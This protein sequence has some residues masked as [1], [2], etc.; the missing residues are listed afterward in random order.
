MKVIN[1]PQLWVLRDLEPTLAAFGVD[2]RC[3]GYQRGEIALHIP[4]RDAGFYL[5][6]GPG[7]DIEFDLDE[8]AGRERDLALEVFQHLP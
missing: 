4:F 2:V 5:L 6:E 7:L 8:W 1:I 3:H